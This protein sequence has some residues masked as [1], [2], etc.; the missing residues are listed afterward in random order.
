MKNKTVAEPQF[1]KERLVPAV[2][3]MSEYAV[4]IEK[5]VTDSL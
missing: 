4:Y 3:P 1:D 2:G 5:C